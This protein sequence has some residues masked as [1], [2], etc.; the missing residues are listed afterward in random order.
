MEWVATD[1]TANWHLSIDTADGI[2]ALL[3][4]FV[5]WVTNTL[6]MAFNISTI[7]TVSVIC[8]ED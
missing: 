6:P 5:C 3:K 1:G 8:P 2:S 4:C 7:H